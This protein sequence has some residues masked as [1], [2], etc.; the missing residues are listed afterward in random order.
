M[1]LNGFSV[2][3]QRSVSGV[4]AARWLPKTARQ[5]RSGDTLLRP[6]SE[7]YLRGL[8]DTYDAAGNVSSE[9]G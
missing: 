1:A 6:D 5:E 7:S 8:L 2:L 4:A 3:H 9:E